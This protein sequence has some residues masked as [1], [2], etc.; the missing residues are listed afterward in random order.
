MTVSRNIKDLHPNLQPLC[1]E[2]LRRAAEKNIGVLITCTFRDGKEQNRL[3]AMG[4]TTKSHVGVTAARPLGR[5]VTNAKASQSAHNFELDGKP[6]SKAFDFVPM[7]GG[8]PIWDE[9]NPNW[10]KLGKIGQELGL[11]WYGTPGS[12][13]KELPHMELKEI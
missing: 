7:V 2:F 8:K 10:Q 11:N 4:R 12:K 1:E 6:A 5:V 9:K 13:F 3:Y